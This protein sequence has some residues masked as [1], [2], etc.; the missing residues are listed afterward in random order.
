MH[1]LRL[2]FASTVVLVSLALST[3]SAAEEAATAKD[4]SIPAQL[5]GVLK[6]SNV[7]VIGELHGTQESPG[8]VGDVVSQLS[9]DEP[10]IVGLELVKEAQPAIDR[11]LADPKDGPFQTVPELQ[12][13]SKYGSFSS[14]TVALLTKLRAMIRS[15]QKGRV[16]LFDGSDTFTSA[17]VR[18]NAMADRLR[19]A[20]KQSP[21]AKLI[22]LTGNL[23]AAAGEKTGLFERIADLKPSNVLV[24]APKGTYWA[25]VGNPGEKS[26]C[27][28]QVL[29]N[30]LSV[31]PV[32]STQPTI[33]PA[34]ELPKLKEMFETLVCFP[35]FTAAKPPVS[36]K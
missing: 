10:W 27:G 4:D 2:L 20:F 29:D 36:G 7:L 33:R 19:A 9:K 15:G 1:L 25:C 3:T 32:E 6:S 14:A 26:V 13:A 21:G 5:A 24:M 11:F 18:D 8:L 34:K 35:A 17:E 12:A 30:H 28:M 16:V 31:C 23:H 22:V